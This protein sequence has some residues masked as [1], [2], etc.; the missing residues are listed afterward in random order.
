MDL[1]PL[2]V[3][4]LQ[5]ARERQVVSSP[6]MSKNS[7][8]VS[9]LGD[10]S[11]AFNSVVDAFFKLGPYDEFGS[12]SDSSVTVPETVATV[13]FDNPTTF[14]LCGDYTEETHEEE[15]GYWKRNE[16]DGE[17]DNVDESDDEISV[18]SDCVPLVM[19]DEDA[20]DE[21]DFTRQ[22]MGYVE[23]FD[24][25]NLN[26]RR[27]LEEE[28]EDDDDDDQR[29]NKMLIFSPRQQRKGQ[30]KPTPRAANERPPLPVA[31]HPSLAIPPPT[32][33]GHRRTRSGGSTPFAKILSHTVPKPVPL[34]RRSTSGDNNR[35]AIKIAPPA[36][37]KAK[38]SHRRAHSRDSADFAKLTSHPMSP[39]Q[40][41]QRQPHSARDSPPAVKLISHSNPNAMP[42]H[43]GTHAISNAMPFHFGTHPGGSTTPL[44]A[45]APEKKR[46]FLRLHSGPRLSTGR[47]SGFATCTICGRNFQDGAECACGMKEV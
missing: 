17:R 16:D 37:P 12:G 38:P 19:T 36:V 24:N 42:F 6:A 41:I 46:S 11:G 45:A 26:V 34:Q 1:P 21:I 3:G 32:K 5:Q 7:S 8:T 40:A 47:R 31:K 29:E 18:S 39:A 33:L 35:S 9:I 30:Q 10:Y 20:I 27:I 13:D 22:L 4:N 44:E 23:G 2:P 14:Q 43:F 15:P 25:F 28:E